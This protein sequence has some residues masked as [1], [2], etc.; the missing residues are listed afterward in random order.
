MAGVRRAPNKE[1]SLKEKKSSDDETKLVAKSTRASKSN[2]GGNEMRKNDEI[3]LR[4]RQI[5]EGRHL[6]GLLEL[7]RS[8]DEV[9]HKVA[10]LEVLE[11]RERYEKS[12]L[13]ADE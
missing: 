4:L 7:S 5:L 8:E 13:C 2:E 10:V 12:R 11:R 9:E 1:G 3:N 6:R